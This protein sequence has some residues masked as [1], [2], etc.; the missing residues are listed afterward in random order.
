LRWHLEH[1]EYLVLDGYDGRYE[2]PQPK[3]MTVAE[4]EK[5][6]GYPVKIVK[7]AE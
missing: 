3:E 1:G 5:E 7:E 6:L 2:V 4:V